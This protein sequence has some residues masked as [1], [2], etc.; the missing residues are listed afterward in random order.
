MKKTLNRKG[1]ILYIVRLSENLD[2]RF[3]KKFLENRNCKVIILRKNRTRNGSS[4]S[5]FFET[6][7]KKE[8]FEVIEGTL[9]ANVTPVV[10]I[11]DSRISEEEL[12]MLEGRLTRLSKTI[13][14]FTDQEIIKDGDIIVV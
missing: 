2:Y 14:V 4:D 1:N 7:D 9:D 8:F 12:I 3:T 11:D 10:A 6:T 5:N 13:K